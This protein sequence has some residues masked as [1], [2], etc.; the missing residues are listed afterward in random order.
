MHSEFRAENWRDR[1]AEARVKAEHMSD[2]EAKAAM[3][4]AAD[5]YDLL[6]EWAEASGD[7]EKEKSRAPA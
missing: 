2:P 7:T 5:S 3:L 6:A 1:A 4:Q